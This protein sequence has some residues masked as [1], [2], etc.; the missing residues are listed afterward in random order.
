[1]FL[2]GF[3]VAELKLIFR[4]KATASDL[5]LG[6]NKEMYSTVFAFVYWFSHLSPQSP[7]LKLHEVTKEYWDGG[8]CW[9]CG[10]V[11][12]RSIIYLCTL[13]PALPRFLNGSINQHNAF[14]QHEWFFISPY[15]SQTEFQLWKI[16]W[17]PQTRQSES[18]SAKHLEMIKIHHNLHL[19][20]E[21]L[22]TIR[23]GPNPDSAMDLKSHFKMLQ[24]SPQTRTS[25]DDQN[26]PQSWQ[27]PK[28]W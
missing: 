19:R 6:V 24:P 9:A 3:W 7:T 20:Q 18:A 26:W 13:A 8:H 15:G 27:C 4:F 21:L 28:A 14:S 22:K 1:M 11:P 10:I 23:T 12:L 17:L 16:S 2:L 25:W 5:R